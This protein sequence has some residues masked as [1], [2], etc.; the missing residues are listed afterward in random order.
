[1]IKY[2]KYA[3]HLIIGILIPGIVWRFFVR[4][5]NGPLSSLYTFVNLI[6]ALSLAFMALWSHHLAKKG[7]DPGF[8]EWEH[9]R[10]QAE[11]QDHEDRAK[12]SDP[13]YRKEKANL[14]ISAAD[15]EDAAR[16]SK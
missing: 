9:F 14:K 13:A 12:W 4:F 10:T 7:N 16:N 15:P 11:L 1:M 2:L 6:V 3:F 5:G 8:I